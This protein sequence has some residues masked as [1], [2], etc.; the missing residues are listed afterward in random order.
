MF[1]WKLKKPAELM[2]IAPIENHREREKG[3][4]VYPVYSRRSGGLSVGINLFPGQKRCPF[5]CPYCEV[6]PFSTNAV[7]SPRQMEEDLRAAIARALEQ[8]IPVRD[9]CFS[10]NG[11]P[12]LSP[13]FPKALKLANRVRGELVP[14]AELVLI[15]NGAGLLQPRLFS[16]LREAATSSTALNIWLKLDAGTPQWYEKINRPNRAAIPFEKLI[17]KIKDF[18][19]CAPVTIQSMVCA[20]DGKG[21]PPEEAQAWET[22]VCELAAIAAAGTGGG[23]RKVQIYGKARPAPEDPKA[24]ALPA[25]YLEARA[26]SLRRALATANTAASVNANTPSPPVEVY[27]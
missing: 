18:T 6:F 13:D 22:L 20:V 16:L 5:D 12:S 17:K 23:I 26:V 25:K 2:P 14:V 3:M 27:L 10:G 15:T 21:S 4:L 7:F 9:I 11:E 8:N 19:A 24:Q 1:I